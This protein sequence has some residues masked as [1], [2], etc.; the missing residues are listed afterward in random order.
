MLEKMVHK[1]VRRRVVQ[2]VVIVQ[3]QDERR[4]D[5]IQIITQGIRK[6]LGVQRLICFHPSHN[7]FTT[8][9]HNGLQGCQK[10][11]QKNPQIVVRF[12][13]GEPRAWMSGGLEPMTDQGSLAITGRCRDQ[14][15]G[16]LAT[17]LEPGIDSISGYHIRRDRRSVQLRSYDRNRL[18]SFGHLC[19][20]DL[21]ETAYA[22]LRDALLHGKESQVP[23]RLGPILFLFTLHSPI[24]WASDMNRPFSWLM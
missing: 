5:V 16:K 6:R 1:F 9:R 23:C 11:T 12:I 7:V 21:P 15:Q 24:L 8:F 22:G 20:G 2:A 13:E 3:Y 10:V 19:N 17:L 4:P 18:F 14:A